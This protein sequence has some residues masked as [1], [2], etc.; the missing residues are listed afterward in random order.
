MLNSDKGGDKNSLIG[1]V[2]ISLLF[3]VMMFMNSDEE[4]P[5]KDA[6]AATSTEISEGNSSVKEPV[7][8]ALPIEASFAD[9][10][11]NGVPVKKE[12]ETITLE[13]DKVKIEFESLGAR[14]TSAFIKD[15]KKYD[16]TPLNLI[17]GD[18]S[19]FDLVFAK[20]GRKVHTNRLIFDV[21]Q[22]KTD[23]GQAIVFSHK[24][25]KGGQISFYY[26]LKNDSYELDFDVKSKNLENQLG[27]DSKVK[28]AMNIV[29]PRQEKNLKNERNLT[30]LFYNDNEEVDNLSESSDDD[31]IIEQAKWFAFKGQF[32]STVL[33]S[34]NGFSGLDMRT[35]RQSDND[36]EY[37][38]D[39]RVETSMKIKDEIN[40][41][42]KLYFLPNNFKQLKSYEQDFQYLIPL[43]WGIFGWIN[44]FVV[45]EIFHFLE[46]F[47]LNYGLVIFIMALV[48]KLALFPLTKK[49][50]TSMAAM[51]VLKPQLDEL[52]AKH[53]DDPAKQQQEQMALYSK[54]GVSPLSGCLPM[55]AQ[56]PIL[57]AL[58]RF[59]PASI[60][61]RQQSFLWADD[62]ST[63]DNV[64]NL[65][66]D[67]WQY[68]SH[69]SLFAL[70]M[71]ASS[72]IQMI[73]NSQN[74]ASGGDNPM[75]KQMK[76]MMYF[77]P[78]IFLGV[79]NSYAAALSYYYFIA[80]MM[81]F[82][83]QYWIRRKTDDAAILAKIE[84]KQKDP[85]NKGGNRI[86][87]RME[88]MMKQQQQMKK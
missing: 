12:N 10:D 52:K 64:Y 35:I 68:G 50:Y 29:V 41:D 17:H 25:A 54:A 30:T 47:D 28:M 11:T 34:E 38:K 5:V 36:E 9:V 6:E 70:L 86:Q 16:G 2:I 71:A 87:R 42:F 65:G 88:E 56:M 48:I 23:D 33:T 3:A 24:D 84:A 61:L 51:R 85:N 45:I 80:N 49:S 72:F 62:L 44:R 1:M 39:L 37:V 60:E 27:L 31:E 76:Y 21:K 53:P 19:N 55:L 7:E 46:G 69:V 75:A 14:V 73:Y 15:Y 26:V 58:F 20:E 82:A 63:Y 57:F 66:F 18:K 67:I 59:F 83:Q 8:D 79:M 13:N 81:T 77:M 32:F 78:I 40:L 4:Q 74:N 22:S 43:G